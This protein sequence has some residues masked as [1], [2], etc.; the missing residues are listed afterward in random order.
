MC[1]NRQP[2]LSREVHHRTFE[3]NMSDS[4]TATK[5]PTVTPGTVLVVE[6]G[7]GVFGQDLLDGRHRLL[8]D[9]PQSVGGN[10]AGPNPYELLLMSLG[11]CTSMTLRMYARRKQL[12]LS[13]VAVRLRHARIHAADC[14]ECETKTGFVDRIDRDIVLEGPLDAEQRKRLLQIADMCPVHRTLTSE[15]SIVTK[16]ALE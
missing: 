6:N 3:G 13:R 8:A 7:N 1:A 5:E 11:A 12:P 9:E 16:L 10:D 2:A 14:A 15:I 4:A